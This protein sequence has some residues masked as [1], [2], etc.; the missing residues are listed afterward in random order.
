MKYCSNLFI[1]IIIIIFYEQYLRFFECI[2]NRMI[3][4]N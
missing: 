3:L 4:I 2:V 1:I